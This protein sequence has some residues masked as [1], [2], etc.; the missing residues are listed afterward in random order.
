MRLTTQYFEPRLLCCG[1]HQPQQRLLTPSCKMLRQTVRSLTTSAARSM[2]APSSS[3]SPDLAIAHAQG[4]AKGL[5]GGA[6]LSLSLS[7]SRCP[8][9][10]SMH[11]LL[12]P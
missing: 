9:N 11:C 3:S 8:Q 12:M 4:I 7:P 10:V 5:T 6:S 1:V 2:A